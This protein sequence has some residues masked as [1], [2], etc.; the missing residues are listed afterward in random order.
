MHRVAI[1]MLLGSC[2]WALMET[3]PYKQD[4]RRE[5]RCTG[6]KG[7]VALDVL[8]TLADGAAILIA[9]QNK[10]TDANGNP[11]LANGAS[12][13]ITV[14]AIDGV[15][16]LVSAITGS[17]WADKCVEARAAHDALPLPVAYRSPAD[18]GIAVDAAPVDARPDAQVFTRPA[19]TEEPPR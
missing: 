11:Q 5:P 9:A 12:T 15:L 6:I 10:T 18:A 16:H 2:S 14:A 4:V 13:A 8:A 3:L 7:F 1:A 17:G 19:D